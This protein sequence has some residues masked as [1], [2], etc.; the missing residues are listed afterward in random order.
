MLKK[1]I[2]LLICLFSCY[3]YNISISFSDEKYN[4][5]IYENI[6]LE[7]E[8]GDILVSSGIGNITFETSYFNKDK[9]ITKTKK[10]EIFFAF[11]GKK[12]RCKIEFLNDDIIVEKDFAYDGNKMDVLEYSWGPQGII[13]VSGAIYPKEPMDY[14]QE[15]QFC[16]PRHNGYNIFFS[17][18]GSFFRNCDIKYIRDEKINNLQTRYFEGTYGSLKNIKLWLTHKY[19]YR[20]KRIISETSNSILIREFYFREYLKDNI[21]IWFPQKSITDIN[22]IN[23]ITGE[24]LL[25]ARQNFIVHDDYKINKELPDSLFVINFP[26]GL[27]IY[28]ERIDKK[29]YIK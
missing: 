27:T 8:Y 12:I 16:D 11:S 28:D 14:L 24:K 1:R 25:T 10:R 9:E 23:K 3:E 19:L 5:D 17:S 6:I 21:S 2:F 15:L 22:N 29:I 18:V 26:K 4:N 13:Q 20:P 7:S